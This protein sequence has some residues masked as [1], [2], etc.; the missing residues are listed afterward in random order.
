M[1]QTLIISEIS[2]TLVAFL[3][4][5]DTPGLNAHVVA[6]EIVVKKF[7]YV[8]YMI[9]LIHSH[10]LVKTDRSYFVR[11]WP[12]FG[13]KLRPLVMSKELPYYMSAGLSY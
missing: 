7:N 13:P 2:V 3:A 12:T 5:S 4:K 1:I 10:N 11:I 8:F 9:F 6:S